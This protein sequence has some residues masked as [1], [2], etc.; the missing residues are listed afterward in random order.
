M[1]YFALWLLS[2]AVLHIQYCLPCFVI[3]VF[4]FVYI[5]FHILSVIHIAYC[6]L[7]ST[8]ISHLECCLMMYS[9]PD[10]FMIY[11]VHTLHVQ[12]LHILSCLYIDSSFC[13]MWHISCRAPDDRS[14]TY[15]IRDHQ[16]TRSFQWC[17][18][19]FSTSTFFCLSILHSAIHKACLT[20]FSWK[21]YCHPH[22]ILPATQ[23]TYFASWILSKIF[24]S[25]HDLFVNYIALLQNLDFYTFFAT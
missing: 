4:Q 1:Y 8:Y 7:R 14:L 21:W 23:Y 24:S 5:A 19:C 6:L 12:F 17:P 11:I 2:Y 9:I 13:G 20:Y 22:C 18:I 16:K 3:A 25:I 10:W 15:V